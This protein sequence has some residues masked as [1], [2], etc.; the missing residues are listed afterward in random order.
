[1]RLQNKVAIVTG[2]ASGFGEAIAHRFAQEG[3]RVVVSDINDN[4]GRPVANAIAEAGWTARY[5]H[6]DVSNADDVAGMVADAESAYG[7][8]DILVNNAGYPQRNQPMLDVSEEEFDR[9]FA[10]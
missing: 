1:M 10:V 7:G 9:I 3:A 5:V 8:L 4:A 2:A 6:A